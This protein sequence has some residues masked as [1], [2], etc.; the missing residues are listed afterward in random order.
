MLVKTCSQ[1]HQCLLSTRSQIG[2]FKEQLSSTLG[3]WARDH[4]FLN[5]VLRWIV[6]P[7]GQA[8]GMELGADPRQSNSRGVDTR[9]AS[10]RDSLRI[11]QLSPRH[12]FPMSRG[13]RFWQLMES[14]CS[15]PVRNWQETTADACTRF[16][17]KYPRCIQSF[18]RQ[19]IVPKQ[20]TCFSDS[21]FSG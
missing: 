11:V 4:N 17:L 10:E 9:R 1:R 14:K 7:F 16:L 20:I 12:T 15:F 8:P 3:H 5:R 2:E 6:P 19:E 21:N 13:L 18:E